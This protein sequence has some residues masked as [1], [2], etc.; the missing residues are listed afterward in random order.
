M[1]RQSQRLVD[2]AV[3]TLLGELLA[4][5]EGDTGRVL[6]FSGQGEALSR[7]GG[8]REWC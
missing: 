4:K 7:G 2:P 8:S 6:A 1:R 5:R 3:N